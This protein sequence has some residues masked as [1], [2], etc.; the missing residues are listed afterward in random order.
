MDAP[1]FGPAFFKR[2]RFVLSSRPCLLY[3]SKLYLLHSVG[4]TPSLICCSMVYS[5]NYKSYLFFQDRLDFKL[6]L[7]FQYRPSSEPYL[8]P[9]PLVHAL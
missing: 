4:K 3:C 2:L 9:P 5:L 6:Y 1:V 7:L 8:L